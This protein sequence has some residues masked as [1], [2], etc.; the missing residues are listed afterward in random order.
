[1]EYTFEDANKAIDDRLKI[2]WNNEN[3]NLKKS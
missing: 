2:L 3:N 1:M